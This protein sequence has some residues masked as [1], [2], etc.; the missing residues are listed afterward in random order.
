[1]KRVD[2]ISANR[3]TSCAAEHLGAIAHRRVPV[4]LLFPRL[5]RGIF[6]H[7]VPLKARF[8]APPDE[9][10]AVL[11]QIPCALAK[12]SLPPRVGN[13]LQGARNAGGINP[14]SGR[15]SKDSL[16][17]SLPTGI[18]RC[19]SA[20]SRS[21]DGASHLQHPATAFRRQRCAQGRPIANSHE[22]ENKLCS[23]PARK[24]IALTTCRLRATH[25][26][27]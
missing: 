27:P 23:L 10:P 9:F 11:R 8:R 6:H 13:L 20:L 21:L 1:M 3:V 15:S 4:M 26:A 24:S 17:H 18:R 2:H 19:R 14:G 5:L 25:F 16:P 22:H 7:R 12:N